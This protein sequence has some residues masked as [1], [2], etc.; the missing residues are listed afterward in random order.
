MDFYSSPWSDSASEAEG[1]WE[2]AFKE[3]AAARLRAAPG[4]ELPP[5]G[6]FDVA[7]RILQWLKLAGFR[8]APEI[9]LD[10]DGSLYLEWQSNSK[11]L[12]VCFSD[13]P[14]SG[15]IYLGEGEGY[16]AYPL[17]V[18]GIQEAMESYRA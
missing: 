17:T 12:T 6:A 10:G 2:E 7:E 4:F 3:L 13:R 11:H 16:K 9:T 18:T 5:E 8:D 14:E 1:Q 15:Y